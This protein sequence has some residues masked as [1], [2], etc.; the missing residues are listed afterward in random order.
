MK[1]L[2]AS[3]V[4]LT[5]L[6]SGTSMA[7]AGENTSTIY[8]DSYSNG[9]VVRVYDEPGWVR[10]RHDRSNYHVDQQSR[11]TTRLNDAGVRASQR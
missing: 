5:L 3:L 2:N 1:T 11:D 10:E 8:T 6:A 7:F 9:Q 4:A